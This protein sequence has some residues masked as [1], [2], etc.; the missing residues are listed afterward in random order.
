MGFSSDFDGFSIRNSIVFWYVFHDQHRN[1]QIAKSLK[2]IAPVE[3]KRKFAR[4]PTLSNCKK[5]AKKTMLEQVLNKAL[6]KR[7]KPSQTPPQ[8]TPK[9]LPKS[10]EIDTKLALN[11]EMNE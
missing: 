9:T 3:A 7:P 11:K 2:N 1:V 5:Q 10:I 8:S 4:F 6:Q